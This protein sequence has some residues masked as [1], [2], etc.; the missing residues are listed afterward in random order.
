VVSGVILLIGAVGW[1]FAPETHRPPGAP[2][3]P[4]RPLGPEAGG[5]VP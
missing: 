4:A 1:T 3:T 5:E 2:P